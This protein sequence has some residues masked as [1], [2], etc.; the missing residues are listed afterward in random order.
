VE[1]T[2]EHKTQIE[3]IMSSMDCERDFEC[4]KSG[5]DNICEAAYRGLDVYADCFDESR[6]TCKFKVPFGRG[7]FCKCPLRVYIAK[8]LKK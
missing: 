5:L 1:L 2:Q 7:T 3:E 8:N 4:Y 6:T